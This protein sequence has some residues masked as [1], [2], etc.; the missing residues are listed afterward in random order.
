MKCQKQPLVHKN[1]PTPITELWEIHLNQTTWAEL[2]ARSKHR[3]CSYST[4]SR[5]C[6]FR[7]IEH[8]NLRWNKL[9]AKKRMEIKSEPRKHRQLMHRHV[10]C[11]YGEDLRA[12]RYAAM[13]LGITVSML[14][15][16]ALTLYLPRLAMENPSRRISNEELFKLG[17][18]RWQNVHHS[19]LNNFRIPLFRQ[20]TFSSFFPWQWWPRRYAI[21]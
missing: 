11:F 3:K 13:V 20:L 6:L 1:M 21:P 15:R 16:I 7:L 12:V 4:V 9:F 8:E 18:K 17:I 19:A 14:V 10:I 5:Y 2:K